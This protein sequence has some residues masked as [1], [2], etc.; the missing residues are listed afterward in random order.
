[1]RF[2][3]VPEWAI[4]ADLSRS[5]LKILLALL[6]FANE[7][8]AAWPTVSTLCETAGLSFSTGRRAY[9]SLKKKGL[10]KHEPGR[11]KRIITPKTEGEPGG[12]SRPLKG[13]LVTPMP[14]NHGAKNDPQKGPTGDPRQGSTVDPLTYHRTDQEQTNSVSGTPLDEIFTA[15][16][17]ALEDN[18]KITSTVQGRKRSLWLEAISHG[19]DEGRDLENLV[20]VFAAAGRFH[21][22]RREADG[23]GAYVSPMKLYEFGVDEMSRPSSPTFD[24]KTWDAFEEWA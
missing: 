21:R 17:R 23:W 24:P 5:E 22:A 14:T 20:E 9:R 12:Q 15:Y 19:L 6:L 13:P 3:K 16:R 1:M 7:Q 10:F 18:P 8:G 4:A 11:V 2:A